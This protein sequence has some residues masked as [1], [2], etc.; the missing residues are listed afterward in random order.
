METFWQSEM[1]IIIIV[2]ADVYWTFTIYQVLCST[3]VILI[4][5]PSYKIDTIIML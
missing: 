1:F 4:L 5:K 2:I 3:C